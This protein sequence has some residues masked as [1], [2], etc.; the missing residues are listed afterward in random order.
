MLDKWQID[1]FIGKETFSLLCLIFK[2]IT[3]YISLNSH[4]VIS[5]SLFRGPNK[6][7]HVHW[8]DFIHWC[9]CALHLI[10]N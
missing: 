6:L 5:F 2:P 3:I 4:S 1:L 8:S 9:I 7:S 10:R